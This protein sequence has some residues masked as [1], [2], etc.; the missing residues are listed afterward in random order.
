[1][2]H[3]KAILVDDTLAMVGS[4][5]MVMRSLLLN[6]EIALS[7]FNK[8]IIAQVNAWMQSLKSQCACREARPK[9]ARDI[10]EGVGRLFAPYCRGSLPGKK[11]P[12]PAPPSSE[13]HM[14][15]KRK[16]SF[17]FNFQLSSG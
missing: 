9:S 11:A 14:G 10:I 1:M 12:I 7:I 4:A 17:T 13:G 2:L 16:N 6:Q 3:A 5:N 15:I 8:P